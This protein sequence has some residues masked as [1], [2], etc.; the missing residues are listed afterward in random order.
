MNYEII[1][2]E[3]NYREQITNI[4][5]ADWGSEIIVTRGNLYNAGE[6]D[7]FIAVENNNIIGILLFNE[8]GLECELLLLQ[9]LKEK[10]GIGTAL[11]KHLENH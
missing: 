1:F 8:T 3:A 9:S 2:I 11:V 10:C 5:R 6:L 4:V 7:G